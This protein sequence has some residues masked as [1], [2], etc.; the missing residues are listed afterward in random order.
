ML[1]YA[2]F[3]SKE[4]EKK[5]VYLKAVN[6]SRSPPSGE[7]K[8]KAEHLKAFLHI[9]RFENGFTVSQISLKPLQIPFEA[10]SR[11]DWFQM[12]M[13]KSTSPFPKMPQKVNNNFL[14]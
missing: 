10:F 13:F 9:L 3:V 5:M 6:I 4:I 11:F 12:D 7:P 2:L 14:W 8:C 1:C